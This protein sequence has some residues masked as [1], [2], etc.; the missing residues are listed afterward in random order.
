LNGSPQSDLSDAYKRYKPT[1]IVTMKNQS[2]PID[3]EL[4]ME[5]AESREKL[6][7]SHRSLGGGLEKANELYKIIPFLGKN[8]RTLI[9]AI[10]DYQ[11]EESTGIMTQKEVWQH[12]LKLCND[13]G[14][15]IVPMQECCYELLL[16]ELRDMKIVDI[17][18]IGTKQEILAYCPVISI[19]YANQEQDLF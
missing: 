17:Q 19:E 1:S 8:L 4:E 5:M 9:Y 14:K 6:R 10:C 11:L 2:L 18:G 16:S 3:E 7:A 13:A 15:R 12:Y